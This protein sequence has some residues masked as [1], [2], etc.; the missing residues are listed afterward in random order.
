MLCRYQIDQRASYLAEVVGCGGGEGVEAAVGEH[1]PGARAS[2]SHFSRPT[3]PRAAMR[4]TLCEAAC[5]GAG[6]RV[7]S[8]G[9]VVRAFAEVDEHPVLEGEAGIFSPN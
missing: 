9:A 5:E 3:R 2:S 8:C 6:V 7:R 1:C 4:S